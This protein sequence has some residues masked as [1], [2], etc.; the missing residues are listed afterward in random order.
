M[1]DLQKVAKE[2]IL[3]LKN[4]GIP[5]QDE[6]IVEIQFARTNAL[7]KCILTLDNE[8]YIK[9]SHLYDN[10]KVDICELEDVVIHELL[11]TCRNCIKH[12]EKWMEYAKK[13]EDVYGYKIICQKTNYDIRH[14]D[15]IVLHR[16]KCSKC[17]GYWDVREPKSW[18]RIQMGEKCYCGLCG[19]EYLL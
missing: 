18:K 2:C 9:I 1:R 19:S 3:K 12:T 16:M 15:K 10:E 14:S 4:I 5:I 11:H 7:G 13:V 17:I 8:Y 6:N